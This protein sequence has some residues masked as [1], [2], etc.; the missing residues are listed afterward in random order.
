[1]VND[2]PHPW[3]DGAVQRCLIIDDQ[4]VRLVDEGGDTAIV[5]AALIGRARLGHFIEALDEL[6]AGASGMRLWQVRVSSREDPVTMVFDAAA[7]ELCVAVG[8]PV[9][10]DEDP[11]FA[12]SVATTIAPVLARW[13]ARASLA[14]D[15]MDRDVVEVLIDDADRAVD[16]L[17]SCGAELQALFAALDGGS[18]SF[19]GARDL[20]L[21]GRAGA[22]VGAGECVWLDAKGAPYRDDKQGAYELAK[23]VA[24]FASAGGGLILI[25]ATTETFDGAE[26]IIDVH[27]LDV[28]LVNTRSWMD[29]IG[30]RVYP[31]PAGV[32]VSFVGGHRGQVLVIVPPQLEARKPFLVRGAIEGQRTL[33]HAITLPWRDGDRTQFDD[34]GVVHGALRAHRRAE[35]TTVN[36]DAPSRDIAAELEASADTIAAALTSGR[37]WDVNAW[38]LQSTEWREGRR[39]LVP[40]AYGAVASAYAAIG[41]ANAG[42]NTAAPR[43]SLELD[44]RALLE[45]TAEGVVAARAALQAALR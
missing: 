8:L 7:Q 36:A 22:L 45:E 5:D 11:T 17:V 44:E 42:A 4:V 2:F 9:A 30:E 20:V 23:D 15:P 39:S 41:R 25:P 16:E 6:S 12:A 32:Q 43:R 21:G 37:W 34:I 1:M 26:V 28:G 33:S 29:R 24:A 3:I 38:G 19:G 10:P 18:L 35:E 13:S 27:E 14:D 31:R 40:G